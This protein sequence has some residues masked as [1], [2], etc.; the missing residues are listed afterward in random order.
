MKIDDM[1]SKTQNHVKMYVY[2]TNVK[3]G[4][5]PWHNLDIS[6]KNDHEYTPFLI[7][8]IRPFLIHD[9]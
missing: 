6:V 7:M 5:S 1:N 3:T 2:I 8:T 4:L 9:L